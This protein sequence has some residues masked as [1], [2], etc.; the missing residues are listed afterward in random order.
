[1]CIFFHLV[2]E[3]YYIYISFSNTCI[4]LIWGYFVSGVFVVVVVVAVVVIYTEYEG[5]Y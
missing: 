4:L 3:L 2:R 5:V 1:M